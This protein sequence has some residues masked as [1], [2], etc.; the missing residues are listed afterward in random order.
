MKMSGPR[1]RLAVSEGVAL[2]VLMCG[3]EQVEGP[4]WLLDLAFEDEFPDWS[5]SKG[6]SQVVTDLRNGLNGTRALI[7]ADEA[8]KT[9]S[10]Y[11][12]DDGAAL[13]I[14]ARASDEV[15]ISMTTRMIE[16]DVPAQGWQELAA[17]FLARIDDP[18]VKP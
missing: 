4:R 6:F 5:Y 13:R 3:R 17:A 16:G 9:F 18:A 11:W 14:R 1:Q 2:G 10:L 8:K 15:S 12:E 7:R